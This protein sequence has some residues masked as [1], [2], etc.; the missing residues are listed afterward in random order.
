MTLRSLS[1]SKLTTT[2]SKVKIMKVQACDFRMKGVKVKRIGKCS[3]WLPGV[4]IMNCGF[5]TYDVDVIIDAHGNPIG[6]DDL[7]EYRLIEGPM[8]Y[9]DVGYNKPYLLDITEKEAENSG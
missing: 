1:G 6:K 5:S 9:I 3:D 4:A 8:S 2:E 7:L